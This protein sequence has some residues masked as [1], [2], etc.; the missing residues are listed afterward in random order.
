MHTW[1]VLQRLVIHGPMLAVMQSL[2]QDNG[3]TMNIHGTLGRLANPGQAL[4][5]VAP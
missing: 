3:L 5:R 1:Q 4:S 2:Y